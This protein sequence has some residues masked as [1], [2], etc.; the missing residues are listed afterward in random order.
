MPKATASESPQLAAPDGPAIVRTKATEK[1]R[2]GA[3][4]LDSI[5]PVSI[6]PRGQTVI[7]EY[8]VKDVVA[9]DARL[10]G[11][12]PLPTERAAEN[13]AQIK[14]FVAMSRF[15]LRPAQL[16]RIRA[17]SETSVEGKKPVTIYNLCDV[18]A[19]AQSIAAAVLPTSQTIAAP[20][21]HV[22]GSSTS[23]VPA[24]V[25]TGTTRCH[26]R[27]TRRPIEVKDSEDYMEEPNF[28]DN[29][30]RDQADEFMADLFHRHG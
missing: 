2:L 16:Q 18:E 13:G 12:L 9:L 19:L 29:M 4:D 11:A 1:Y 8:N 10:N 25:S 22:A 15:K 26:R 28:F 23:S 3:S 7:R 6:R 30:T 14:A 24:A 21:T 20:T 27:Q 5:L 17:V